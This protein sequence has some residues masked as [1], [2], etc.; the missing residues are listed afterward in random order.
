MQ[1]CSEEATKL[2]YMLIAGEHL[3]VGFVQLKIK[4]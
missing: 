2:K 3:K 1:P 4:Y